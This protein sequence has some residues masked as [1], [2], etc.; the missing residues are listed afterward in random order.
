MSADELKSIP[1]GHFVV[2]KTGCHPMQTELRLFLEWGISFE[3]AYTV[4]KRENAYIRYAGR[5]ELMNAI[6]EKYPCKN[7]AKVDKAA[8]SKRETAPPHV[9]T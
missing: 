3:E 2:M 1:K 7:T 4:P 6:M 9:K 5:E 8:E